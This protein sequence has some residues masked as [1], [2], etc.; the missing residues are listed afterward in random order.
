M[1][2]YDDEVTATIVE[3]CVN[4]SL[5]CDVGNFV[6]ERLLGPVEPDC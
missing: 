2:G 4:Q 3:H 6:D 5:E 1:N